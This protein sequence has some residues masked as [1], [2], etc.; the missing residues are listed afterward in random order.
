MTANVTTVPTMD[1]AGPGWSNNA[2]NRLVVKATAGVR[3]AGA[4]GS[5]MAVELISPSKAAA[6]AT[7]IEITEATTA[8]AEDK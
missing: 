4:C 1:L 5:I 7:G 2:A 6:A 3:T 8:P